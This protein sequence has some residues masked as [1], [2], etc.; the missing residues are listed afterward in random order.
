M[1]AIPFIGVAILLVGITMMLE[2]GQMS[3]STKRQPNVMLGEVHTLSKFGSIF[4]GIIVAIVGSG[5]LV[6]Y[7][8]I[9]PSE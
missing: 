7:F 3:R 9:L 1:I 5:L 4:S 6:F 8:F 2:P